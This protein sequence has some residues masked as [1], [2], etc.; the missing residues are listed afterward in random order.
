M[1]YIKDLNVKK[2]CKN[3][4][5]SHTGEDIYNIKSQRNEIQNIDFHKAVRKKKANRKMCK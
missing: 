5:T 3:A 1:R 2:Q 4:I